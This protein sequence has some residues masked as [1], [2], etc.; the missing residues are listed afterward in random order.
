M[1]RLWPAAVLVPVMFST[2]CGFMNPA[3]AAFEEAQDLVGKGEYMEAIKVYAK[4]E[5]TWPDSPEAA[6]VP[7]ATDDAFVGWVGQQMEGGN[8]SDIHGM[9]KFVEGRDLGARLPEG[10]PAANLVGQAMTTGADAD[11]S[12]ALLVAAVEMTPPK[13]IR[14]DIKGWACEHTGEF[15]EVVT[16]VKEPGAACGKTV[17]LVDWCA[18]ED[19]MVA[20]A[21]WQHAA[22][23]ESKALLE[24]LAQ[25]DRECAAA[26]KR[27][28]EIED[29]YR[30]RVIAGDRRAS[31]AFMQ[32]QRPHNQKVSDGRDRV[33]TIKNIPSYKGWPQ[34]IATDIEE[35]VEG[36][37]CQW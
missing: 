10:A 33:R 8:Y 13:K 36:T 15:P 37:A 18:P 30:Y 6:R 1:H 21:G 35:N 26:K 19:L 4:I 7:E 20:V 24:E 34:E 25:L 14:D 22:A 23:Q 17:A 27:A 16:C 32:E 31:T 28:T 3:G 12:L 11:G 9:W 2:A 29:K 5:K